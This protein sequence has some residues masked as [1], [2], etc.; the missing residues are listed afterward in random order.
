MQRR[1]KIVLLVVG[2]EKQELISRL[3]ERTLPSTY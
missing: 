3:T 1:T 2:L